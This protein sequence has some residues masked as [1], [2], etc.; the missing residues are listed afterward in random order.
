MPFLLGETLARCS[1]YRLSKPSL[2]F[3]DIPL[4]PSNLSDTVALICL[5]GSK[6]ETFLSDLVV[7]L[8][9]LHQAAAQWTSNATKDQ[10]QDPSTSDHTRQARPEYE[11]QMAQDRL[12]HIWTSYEEPV[13]KQGEHA[14]P[15]VQSSHGAGPPA[16][17]PQ[18]ALEANLGLQLVVVCTKV[19]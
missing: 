19:P 15:S 18:G 6:P 16:E 11:L 17:L 9:L 10:Q 5:D 2:P 12:S 3:L 7:W 1:V 14:G 13:V 4:R 8:S